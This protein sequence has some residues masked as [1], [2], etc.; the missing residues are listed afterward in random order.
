MG[1]GPWT[2]AG[3]E[4]VVGNHEIR[5]E[6]EKNE[7]RTSSRDC[8]WHSISTNWYGQSVNSHSTAASTF[9]I[10][11]RL[12]LQHKVLQPYPTIPIC[13]P[14]ASQTSSSSSTSTSAAATAATSHSLSPSPSQHWCNP[15]C[16]MGLGMQ[17][18]LIRARKK[19]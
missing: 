13:N 8:S 6:D 4:N 12:L 19:E 16:G 5:S 1:V 2:L 17:Q 14:F 10:R 9:C 18:R 3:A 11:I 7:A 15:I